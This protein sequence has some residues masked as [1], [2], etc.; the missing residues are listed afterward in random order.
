MSKE[1][2]KNS[3][4]VSWAA[5]GTFAVAG[6]ASVT[7]ATIEVG[8]YLHKKHVIDCDING[9]V[10]AQ[11]PEQVEKCRTYIHA[12]K[13]ALIGFDANAS[14]ITYVVDGTE[15]KIKQLFGSAATID[16]IAPNTALQDEYESHKET[17][18]SGQPC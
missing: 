9:S 16:V 17:T 14:Q 4:F 6:I 18:S 10:D 15:E 12:G 7:V 5:R 3:M 2:T 8:E 13:I 11:D 1:T